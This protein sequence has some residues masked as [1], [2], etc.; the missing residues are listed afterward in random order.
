MQVTQCVIES[1]KQSQVCWLDTDPRLRP[2]VGVTLKD[3]EDTTL[4]WKVL[5]LGKTQE[6]A[7]VARKGHGGNWYGNDFHRKDGS[8]QHC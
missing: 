5:S 4:V 8:W 2:G 7:E 6:K 3:A 1:G